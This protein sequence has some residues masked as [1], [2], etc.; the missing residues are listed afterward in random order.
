M[1][2]VF[3]GF[4]AMGMALPVL[5]RHVHE[6]LGQGTVVVGFVMGSQYLSAVFGRM[7]AGGS[8]DARGPKH[9]ALAGLGFAVAVGAL[10]LASVP[11]A[12]M[13]DVA[14][15]LV[16]AGRLLSGFA[17]A[18]VIT[19]TLAWGLARVGPAHAGK[20]F[21]WMGVALFAGFAAGA[22]AGTFLHG[23]FGFAGVAI[24]VVSVASVGWVATHRIAAVAPSTLP[25]LPFH[26][27]L[28][29]VKL[30]GL[31]LTLC[32]LGY[33]MITAFAVLLFAERGW[34]G[35]ALA[36]SCMG[37]GF[38]AGRLLFGQLPDRVGGARVAMFCV[39]GEAVGLALLWI[40]PHPAVAWFGAALAGGGYGLGFQGFGVEAVRRA[41]AQSR[42]S[43]M[44]AYVIFQDVSMGLGPPLGGLLAQAAGLDA[45]YLAAAVGAVGS[46]AV[47]AVLARRP[48]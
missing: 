36:V 38:I 12:G 3:A 23:H 24:A 26:R 22:P 13:P 6:A 44:G 27:V 5:P 34:G 20:V 29:V 32:S 10:Y 18:F 7:V 31:G 2:T 19:S 15:L 45:V 8:V 30:P 9:A 33:A 11:F 4:F 16:L 46:A 14:L 1:A 37:V 42:G 41:P 48:A 17:E 40:A 35:G 39:L 47:A 28:G 21:G 43:A 25:R